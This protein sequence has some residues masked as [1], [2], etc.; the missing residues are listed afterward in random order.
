MEGTSWH[1]LSKV[2]S[3]PGDIKTDLNRERLHQE[4]MD[5]DTICRSFAW[6]I[7]RQAKLAVG[8]TTYVGDTALTVPP[9]FKDVVRGNSTI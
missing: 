5:K 3:S 6:K 1:L 8:A 4:T 7:L 2:F 9:F